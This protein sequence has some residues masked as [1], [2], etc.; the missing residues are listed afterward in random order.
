MTASA[1]ASPAAENRRLRA[2]LDDAYGQMAELVDALD[3]ANEIAYRRAL[4][5]EAAAASR[6]HAWAEGYVAAIGDVKRTQHELVAD[7]QLEARRW[8]LCCRPCRRS[9]H[10]PGCGECRDRTRLTFGQALS[11]DYPGGRA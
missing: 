4:C 9:G 10:R 7:L 8:H 2:E 6:E 11:G 3:P 1:L 5:R